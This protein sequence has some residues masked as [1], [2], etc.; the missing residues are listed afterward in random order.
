MN[1]SVWLNRSARLFPE[2][3]A[4]A[5]GLLW[6]GK[7]YRELGVAELGCFFAGRP[8]PRE[9][10]CVDKSV[11]LPAPTGQTPTHPPPLPPS[12]S[13]PNNQNNHVDES[14][15]NLKDPPPLYPSKT[16]SCG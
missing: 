4:L 5:A 12:S 8:L 16:K 7:G 10:Q 2:G 11:Q 9:K 6:Q 14:V 15:P 3:L 1:V 13:L